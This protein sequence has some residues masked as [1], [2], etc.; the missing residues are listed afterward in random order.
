MFDKN[1]ILKKILKKED[2]VLVG[3]T[4]DKYVS[5]IELADEKKHRGNSIK[6]IF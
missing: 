3:N 6:I 1:E 5:K 4:L 2:K